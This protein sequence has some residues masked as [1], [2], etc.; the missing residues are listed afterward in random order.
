MSDKTT[1]KVR[2]RRF[3]DRVVITSI[4]PS[5]VAAVMLLLALPEIAN[6]QTMMF[7][8]SGAVIAVSDPGRRLPASVHEGARLT[9]RYT[10]ITPAPE[11]DPASIAAEYVM[12]A[13]AGFQV[14]IGELTVGS[15]DGLR[16]TA[17]NS[18]GS[19]VHTYELEQRAGSS[20]RLIARARELRTIGEFSSE[21]LAVTAPTVDPLSD[22]HRPIIEISMPGGVF[23]LATADAFVEA[24][25]QKPT[26]PVVFVHGTCSNET[27]WSALDSYVTAGGWAPGG[28]IH[29]PVTVEGLTGAANADYYLVRFSN[30]FILIGLESWSMELDAY[31]RRIAAFRRAQGITS[32][33]RFILVAHSAGGL[34]ARHYI[35][36]Q[37]YQGNVRHLITYGTPHMGIPNAGN[38]L[39]R[40]L[41]ESGCED[42]PAFAVSRGIQ[43][44]DA[45]S[46]FLYELNNGSFP[47]GMF[48]TSLIGKNDDCASG[49]LIA[50]DDDCVVST[51]SQNI[52]NIQ[53]PPPSEL[54]TT[55]TT[56]R[57]HGTETSDVEAI[58]WA[59]GN[60]P[61]VS[62]TSRFTFSGRTRNGA[63]CTG[64]YTFNPLAADTNPDPKIG[65]FRMSAPFGFE[66]RVAGEVIFSTTAGLTI[67]VDN[68][69]D[70]VEDQ[71]EVVPEQPASSDLHLILRTRNLGGFLSDALPTTPPP[72]GVFW[73]VFEG[74]HAGRFHVCE[75][76]SL[77]R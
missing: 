2:D 34:A 18:S 70:G 6:A 50:G 28:T 51:A 15:F 12:P 17:R 67:E 66:A 29:N 7:R 61:T 40:A 21:A 22:L 77:T 20:L 3:V 8:V 37:R 53:S 16:I 64:S 33:S 56:D 23:I 59:I 14:Q 41:V 13:P 73:G 31:L 4:R 60:P 32:P 47:E 5:L 35:Q 1:A 75:I 62:L 36:S 55:R 58:L 42:V 19:V 30:P 54:V 72:M 25:I 65:T 71:Y 43:E 76:E 48:H 38:D 26:V 10:M 44:M 45:N 9:G 49:H 63:E 39:V 46:A 52:Q 27:T 11:R 74:D 57:K 24:N 69:I 68:D